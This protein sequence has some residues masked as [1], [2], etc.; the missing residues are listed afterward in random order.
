M[1]LDPNTR[2]FGDHVNAEIEIALLRQYLTRMDGLLADAQTACESSVQAIPEI[3]Q[4]I[5]EDESELIS[6]QYCQ[7]MN[8]GFLISVAIFLERQMREFAF[9]LKKA[10]PLELGLG[11]MSG[12]LPER[13]RKYCLHV[14]RLPSLTPDPNWQDVCGFV[15]IRN[16]LV[17][18][19]GILDGFGK[20]NSIK[21]FI[22]RHG[23]PCINTPHLVVDAQTSHR[24][25]D[26]VTD[27]IGAVYSVALEVYPRNR[28]KKLQQDKGA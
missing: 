8:A 26:I 14:A 4:V 11:D 23:T 7:M 15:E 20:V 12:S 9:A 19:D 24:C 2:F 18:A 25:L 6:V 3:L 22:G 16:C 21:S 10:G 1:V 28:Y 17:H 13:F 27:F 5:A